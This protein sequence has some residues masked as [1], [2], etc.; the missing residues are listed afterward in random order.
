MHDSFGVMYLN[1][2]YGCIA[3]VFYFLGL[4][5]IFLRLLLIS[6]EENVMDT[7]F[8]SS[9]FVLVIFVTQRRK[10]FHIFLLKGQI[11]SSICHK[12]FASLANIFAFKRN[13][14]CETSHC[15]WACLSLC[16]CL[17]YF[18]ISTPI[19]ILPRVYQ[20]PSIDNSFLGLF[21]LLVSLFF[22]PKKILGW[23]WGGCLI[24][25]LGMNV[26]SYT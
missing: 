18:C 3:L 21:T 17:M 10:Q 24:F 20:S 13:D 6:S 9:F 14:Y 15:Y 2:F 16:S 12:V 7:Y 22:F 25:S 5:L 4:W 19:N 1:I 26:L 11:T 23:G 8:S